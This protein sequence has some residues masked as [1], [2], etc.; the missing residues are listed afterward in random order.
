MFEENTRF[1]IVETQQQMVS[2]SSSSSPS[3][4]EEIYQLNKKMEDA[5]IVTMRQSQAELQLSETSYQTSR[6]TLYF[7]IMIVGSIAISIAL[8]VYAIKQNNAD[9]ISWIDNTCRPDGFIA[10]T[11]LQIAL[12][13]A[14]PW[15]NRLFGAGSDNLDFAPAI[16]LLY[17]NRVVFDAVNK[18]GHPGQFLNCLRYASIESE[19]SKISSMKMICNALCTVDATAC[20]S[21][22]LK[23]CTPASGTS[24]TAMAALNGAVSGM[25]AGAGVGFL[26]HGASAMLGGLGGP[27]AFGSVA[28]G[29]AFNAFASIRANDKEKERQK[30][31]CETEKLY[32]TC[33]VGNTC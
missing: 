4:D 3:T 23:P 31:I 7:I 16:L 6:I 13:N 22:C 24:S 12:A 26:F 20:S 5:G 10:A 2:S 15:Y 27:L 33:R 32:H 14:W 18:T 19:G 30:T 29:M 17:S 25:G 11:G 28:V 8:K 9:F 21:D 1:S